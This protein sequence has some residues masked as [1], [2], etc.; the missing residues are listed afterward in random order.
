MKPIRFTKEETAALT[1]ELQAYFRD[2]LEQD[3]GDLPAAML[4]DFLGEKLGGYFYNRGLYD[5]Q[6]L[7]A[8][9]TED[10]ADAIFGLERPVG[11]G[12]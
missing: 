7:V 6:A 12:R 8:A 10:L 11:P 3:L 1:A 5:A 4:I 9:R 2:E